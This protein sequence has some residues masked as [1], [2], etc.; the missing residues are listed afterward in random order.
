[1]KVDDLSQIDMRLLVAFNAL[2]EELSVT[3]AADRLSS[4]QPAMSRN[5]RQLR[6]LFADEL[7]TRQSHGL[8]ATPGR[9]AAPA[10]AAFAG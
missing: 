7:F 1:M 4:S 8:A 6:I 2:M 10:D 3:R 5:L 9:T